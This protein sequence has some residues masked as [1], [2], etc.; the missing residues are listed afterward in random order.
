MSEE[1]EKRRQIK[2][3]VNALEVYD[4][5]KEITW[6][7]LYKTGLRKDEISNISKE[8]RRRGFIK[9]DSYGINKNKIKEIKAFIDDGLIGDRDVINR[10]DNLV[11]SLKNNRLLIFLM[12]IVVGAI[13]F[14][15]FVNI[16]YY[17]GRTERVEVVYTIR[18]NGNC[19]AIN[20]TEV[21]NEIVYWDENC[22]KPF[23]RMR[24]DY[25]FNFTK[26]NNT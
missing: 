19:T 13:T 7:Q 9:Q 11:E 14:L 24:T 12:V 17:M 3:L 2:F 23:P 15:Y 10:F 6:N 4:A 1:L 8:L 18:F 5:G 21:D 20:L 22:I 25:E 16:D 26:D